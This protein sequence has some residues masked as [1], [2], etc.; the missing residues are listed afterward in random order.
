MDKPVMPWPF[1]NM[2]DRM[3]EG[4]RRYGKIDLENRDRDVHLPSD[5]KTCGCMAM[6]HLSGERCQNDGCR[7]QEY[8]KPTA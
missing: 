7:C 3:A 5:C 2:V 1:Y 4:E 8:V 6:S